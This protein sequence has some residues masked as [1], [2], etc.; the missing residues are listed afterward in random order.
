M[1]LAFLFPFFCA[2]VLLALVARRIVYP[3]RHHDIDHVIFLIRK[4]EVSDLEVLLDVGAEWT[5][6]RSLSPEA[7]RGAQEDRIRLIR[8][9]LRRVAHNVEM[10]QLWVAGEYELIKD[11]DRDTYTEKDS[12]VA[13]ALQVAL[14]L[15]VYTLGARTKVWFWTV[16]R[17]DLWP[18][19]LVPRLSDLRVQCGVNVLA[20]YRRLTE[21][22]GILSLGYGNSYHERFLDAL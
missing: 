15:R 3:V 22:A 18:R 11:K 2:L 17:M 21:V 10:I 5:L 1:S 12:L 14:E 6:R 9:Y 20:K 13:E 8:E 4:L 19:L 7:Y 16:L